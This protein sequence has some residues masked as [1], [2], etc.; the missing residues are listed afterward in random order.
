[1]LLLLLYDKHP[2]VAAAITIVVLFVVIAFVY[3]M[4]EIRRLKARLHRANPDDDI[5][6]RGGSKP[7]LRS[8]AF[9]I[10]S[11]EDEDMEVTNEI[12]L[13]NHPSIDSSPYFAVQVQDTERDDT[14]KGLE[15]ST[16]M[17]L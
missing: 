2:G 15:L 9:T 6:I 11:H 1:L 3:F 8:K 7:Y 10:S 13:N 4:L 5:D 14:D 17:K 12:H 16:R